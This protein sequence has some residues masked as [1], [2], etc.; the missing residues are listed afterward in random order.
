P[1]AKPKPAAKPIWPS[2]AS[3]LPKAAG[4][5]RKPGAFGCGKCRW[6]PSGCRGC[7]AMHEV[8]PPADPLPR[9]TFLPPKQMPAGAA[10]MIKSLFSK[11]SI[12]DGPAVVDPDGHG[13]V[14]LVPLRRGT[15]IHDPTAYFE[16]KPSAYAQAHLEE[17]D[18]IAGGMSSY[19]RL[20]EPV[21]RHVAITYFLNEARG[22]GTEAN[23]EWLAKGP[24]P[25]E[26][27]NR[28]VWR[29]LKEIGAGEELLVSYGGFA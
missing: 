23:V 6:F 9:G 17:Y 16:P 24:E 5:T 26:S 8:T 25:G 14:A 4:G 28:L 10:G 15:L 22:E 13:V 21:L 29:V 7:I 3:W 19:V 27:G 12:V 11:V 1:A 20:R 18:Y 2:G